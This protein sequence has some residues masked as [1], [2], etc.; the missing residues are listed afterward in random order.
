M[1]HRFF[2]VN[3]RMSQWL[4][5]RL[6]QARVDL[7]SI[8]ETVVA[9]EMNARSGQIVA[10]VGGGKS[11]PFAKHRRPDL[12]T[13][14]IAVD[15][16]P[17]ELRENHD[18]D[19]TRVANIMV[20]LPF[21]A[22]EVDM[23][24]SRSVLEHLTDLEA[25]VARSA[26]SL[27]PGGAFIHLVPLRNAPFALVNRALPAWLSRRVMYFF[28]PRTVGICGFPAYYDRCD[29][30]SLP[31]LLDRHGFEVEECRVSYYQSRYYNFFVP[32]Y[33][34]SAAYELLAAASRQPALGAYALIV[35]RR[36]GAPFE[37]PVHVDE[38]APRAAP[39][40]ATASA[41]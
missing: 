23:I 5:R 39:R 10:D 3:R 4:E 29:V 24:V 8:Y 17:D 26:A 38:T 12:G 14:I 19:E 15:V 36:R 11:C 16:A 7:F 31:K 22:G 30:T 21:T 32:F 33:L 37:A 2:D 13:R 6:P 41:T 34:M 9:R 25:F 35:A 18:V 27:K 28:H 20:D 1:L 40:G